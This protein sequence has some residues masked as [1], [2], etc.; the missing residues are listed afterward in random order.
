MLACHYIPAGYKHW[1]HVLWERMGFDG[2][3]RWTDG[4]DETE[5]ARVNALLPQHPA[6]ALMR[7]P[8]Q[9]SLLPSRRDDLRLCTERNVQEMDSQ[10]FTRIEGAFSAETIAQI[11]AE[12][13]GIEA[14]RWNASTK[15]GG[16]NGTPEAITFS[17]G[18]C[19]QSERLR[20]FCASEVFASICWD[21]LHS[22]DCRLYNEQA[23]YKR[24][25]GWARKFPF[26]QVSCHD[27]AA[28]SQDVSDIVVDRTTG[29]ASSSRC[30]T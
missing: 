25:T 8:F 3:R 4:A 14:R 28:S 30:S 2:S 23:V 5:A 26:H 21:V 24:P 10:G 6:M 15:G 18:L 27:I 19:M 11:R 17:S 20:E 9:P 22:P 7:A 13:D 1:P 12:I 16:I 29:T